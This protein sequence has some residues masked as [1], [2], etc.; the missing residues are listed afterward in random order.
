MSSIDY[1]S[2]VAEALSSDCYAVATTG[3][4]L[5]EARPRHAICHLAISDGHRNARDA[6]MGGVLFTLADFAFAAAANAE[7]I[8]QGNPPSWLTASAQVHFLAQPHGS[9]L[10]ATC[11]CLRQGRSRSLFQTEIHD[12]EQRLVAIVLSEGMPSPE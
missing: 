1:T 5:L 7:T 2:L 4:R 9:S 8:A 12:D 10:S 11:S 6:V 3:I